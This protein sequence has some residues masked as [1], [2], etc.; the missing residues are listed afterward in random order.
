MKATL[1]LLAVTLA[2]KLHAVG[3]E[4]SNPPP[5]ATAPANP[6]LA[7]ISDVPGLPRVLLIGDSISIGYTLAVREQLQGR[8]NVHRVPA[9]S[10]PTVRGLADLKSWLGESDWDVIHFNFG[11]HDMVFM[12]PDGT[13]LVSPNLP[14]AHHQVSLAD[15]E[16]NLITIVKQLQATGAHL[17]WCNTTPVPEG[18]PGRISDEA[19]LYN[20]T[21]ASVMNTFRIPINDL[22]SHAKARQAEIQLPIDVHFTPQGYRYLAE[23]VAAA[24]DRALPAA[25]QP[26]G[27]N[28]PI[29]LHAPGIPADPQM[30]AWQRLHLLSSERITIFQGENGVSGFNHHPA[31]IHH[32]GLYF[33]TWS[34]GAKDEDASGQ[35]VV[36][37]TSR[38]GRSWSNPA[39][40][41]DGVSGRTFTPCG[42]WV[43]DNA[44]FALASLRSA[45][46][47]PTAYESNPLIAYRWNPM[48]TAFEHEGIVV[49]NFFAHDAPLPMPDGR[50]LMFGKSARA[51]LPDY[52]MAVAQRSPPHEWSLSKLPRTD[53]PHDITW[54][55]LSNDELVAI[56]AYGQGS[57]RRLATLHS[58]DGGN[59]WSERLITNLPDGDS[60]LHALKLS[61]G[62]YVI[63]NNPNLARYRIPLSIA[64][65][66]DGVHYDRIANVR[67]E[68]TNKRYSGHA[69][70]PGYQY[71]RAIESAGSVWVIY[72]VNKEDIELSIIPL[73]ELDNLLTLGAAHTYRSDAAAASIVI[74]NTD[75]GFTTDRPWRTDDSAA[76]RHG[77]DYATLDLSAESNPGW[78]QWTPEITTPGIYEIYLN[79]ATEGFG[80]ASPMQDIVPVEIS[81]A[82]GTTTT[83]VDQTRYPGTWIHLG[84]FELG[85]G[86]SSSVRILARGNGR[87]VA[88]AVRFTKIN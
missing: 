61:N 13:R 14:G 87:V 69:K 37:A 81:H 45:R 74:D 42:F 47:N 54:Y 31:I 76:G 44:L 27:A 8:A 65:S 62:R 88:D 23:H 67:V 29:A 15:Y 73:E 17:I 57:D 82:K 3:N 10:G 22:H 39:A 85:A 33:A 32:D 63:L 68:Q 50:W 41:A 55:T 49:D 24:I 58:T 34:T 30:I 53:T 51:G 86:T 71:A 38:D 4:T 66:K 20:E 84:S 35:R 78:A 5:A 83:T 36:Y 11:L 28:S 59:R 60:R 7:A 43:R 80:S 56:E 40:L 25:V 64:V 9:N 12:G 21:A 77:S 46:G 19:I 18:A 52:S 1:L 16:R 72:S 79:W 6:A 26:K 75:R 48:T 2:V 70:A